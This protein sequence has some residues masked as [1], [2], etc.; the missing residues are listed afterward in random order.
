MI[1]FLHSAF[2]AADG[3]GFKLFL[4]FD[5][6]GNGP[7]PLSDVVAL[8]LK[9]LVS[10]FESPGNA[11]DWP[12]IKSQTGGFFFIPDWSSLGAKAAREL[13]LENYIYKSYDRGTFVVTAR[14]VG[15]PVQP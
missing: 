2:S 15:R 13:V 9:S 14:P 10:T 3:I 4:S 11:S 5:Y 8:L 1:I 12:T 7:W 6:A